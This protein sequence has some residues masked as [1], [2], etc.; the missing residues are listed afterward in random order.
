M[1][2]FSVRVPWRPPRNAGKEGDG[3]S[4][5]P[6]ARTRG[7]KGLVVRVWVWSGCAR[8]DPW[9]ASPW[10]LVSRPHRPPSV[11]AG[12]VR[13]DLPCARYAATLVIVG[14]VAAGGA[15]LPL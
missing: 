10:S 14:R 1:G 13:V 5:L 7:A 6:N 15:A 9:V 2:A 11:P 3:A 12:L 4:K 8:S